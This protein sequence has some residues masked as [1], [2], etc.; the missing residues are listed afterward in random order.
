MSD[1]QLDVLVEELMNELDNNADTNVLGQTYA[2]C[3]N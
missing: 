1:Q 2:M 3:S